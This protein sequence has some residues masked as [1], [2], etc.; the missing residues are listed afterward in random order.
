MDR[1]D[2]RGGIGQLAL[3][4]VARLSG[5]LVGVEDRRAS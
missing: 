4:A 5:L 3:E 1:Q 2:E